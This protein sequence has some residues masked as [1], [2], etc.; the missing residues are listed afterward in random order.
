MV[1][2]MSRLFFVLAGLFL[3]HPVLAQVDVL[4]QHNDAG[5]SGA[6]LNETTL[7]TANVNNASFGK[8][9]FRLVDGNIYA[10]PL[11]VSQAK[12][13]NRTGPQ[14]VAIVATEHNSVYAFDAE[15]TISGCA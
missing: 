8:L 5:R 2:A 11:I 14:N 3:A 6:N 13:A 12:I 10:Q 9:A 1:G 4:T 15:D 7:T